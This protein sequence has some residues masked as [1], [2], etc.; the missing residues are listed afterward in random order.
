VLVAVVVA[1]GLAV[2]L[3]VSK[4]AEQHLFRGEVMPPGA[5]P[6]TTLLITDVQ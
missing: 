6:E 2:L 3:F 1:L 4:R 5:G